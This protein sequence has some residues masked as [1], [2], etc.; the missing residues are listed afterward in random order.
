MITK[1][2]TQEL[3][4]K[5]GKG[6]NDSGSTEVQVAILT[7]RINNLMP[8]FNKHKHDFHGKTGLLKL[9]GRRR[10]LLRYLNNQSTDRY[11][12]LIKELGLRK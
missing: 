3:V 2:R 10:S 8:H 5:F 6:A 4:S 7:E 9:I 1:E 12:K 11:S